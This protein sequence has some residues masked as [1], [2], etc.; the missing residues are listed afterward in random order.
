MKFRTAKEIGAAFFMLVLVGIGC[1]PV[2]TT[3][4]S[5]PE[6]GTS[7]G[8]YFQARLTPQKQ[9]DS[10]FTTFLLEIQNQSREDLAID[11]NHT[12]YMYNGRENGLFVFKDITPEDVK[13]RSIPLEII[14]A[15]N[16]FSKV[17]APFKLLSRAPIRSKDDS[18]GIK[19]GIL[20]AGEN[21]MQLV[22]RHGEETVTELMSV[23]ITEQAS[24]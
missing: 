6:T 19:G 17:V 22:I 13:N 5:E 7:A 21:G 3:W 20:P 4:T 9:G 14:P 15:G 18:A 10:F 8:R 1:A 12:F 11:W 16:S 2:N 23:S 24:P